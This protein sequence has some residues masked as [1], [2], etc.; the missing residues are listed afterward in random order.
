[1]TKRLFMVFSSMDQCSRP[2]WF[3]YLAL[4]AAGSDLCQ[5][6]RSLAAAAARTAIVDIPQRNFVAQA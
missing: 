3:E 5:T 6:N 1:M 4:A 2:C